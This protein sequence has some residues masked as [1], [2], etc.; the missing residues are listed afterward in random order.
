MALECGELMHQ[1]FAAV[2]IW[3]L[4][5][6]QKLPLHAQYT[7]KRIFKSAR[8]N[9]V[10]NRC[11]TQTD[12]RDQLL[13][14]CFGVLQSSGWKDNDKDQTRT[15][16]NMEL[17]SICYADESLP[18]MDNWPIYVEDTSNPQSMVGIEQVFDVVLTYED[19]KE[20]RY[21]GTMDG[22]VR[23]EATGEY[24][25]DENKT[26]SRLGDAWR[27]AFDM[28]H[29]ITGY[30]AAST[31]VFGFEVLRSR[32]TGLRIKPTNKGEDVYPFEPIMRRWEDVQHWASWVRENAET[33]E[34]YQTDFEHATRRTHSC[35]R[36]F[37]PCSLL[38]FCCDPDGAAGRRLAFDELMVPAEPS[39]SERAVADV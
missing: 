16:T 29:Q 17:A 31:S 18:K 23:K 6:V 15:M 8:W 37:R 12:E 14:L 4:E 9:A 34:R 38:S 24:Y 33:Y 7:G 2:R 19:G 25:I 27:D 28:R 36:Y 11:M 22:L 10:W 32:V 21:V 3:Q 39:P 30:C 35:N 13:E 20:I 26:A 5:K 1:V